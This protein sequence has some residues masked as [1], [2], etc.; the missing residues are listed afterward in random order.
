MKT[1]YEDPATIVKVN[2]VGEVFHEDKS[3]GVILRITPRSS[4]IRIT[5]T[6]CYYVPTDYNGLPGFNIRKLKK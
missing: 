2:I 5:A 6:N 3:S 4:S 1:I